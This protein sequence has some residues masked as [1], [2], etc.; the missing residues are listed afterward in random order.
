VSVENKNLQLNNQNIQ[1][2]KPFAFIGLNQVS[3]RF[4]LASNSLAVLYNDSF[5]GL[6]NLVDLDLSKNKINFI[7]L[8]AFEGLQSLNSLDLSSNNLNSTLR[9]VFA[10]LTRLETLLLNDNEIRLLNSDSFDGLDGLGELTLAN[11]K[12]K[13]IK[14]DF[15]S[16]LV[17]LQYLDLAFNSIS[18]IEPLSFIYLTNLRGL[19]L[20][21][22]CIYKLSSLLFQNQVLLSKLILS[23]N[24][25][26]NIELVFVNLT[27]LESLSL[28][29]NAIYQLSNL[30]FNGLNNLVYLN[31]SNN[32]LKSLN[33]SLVSLKSLQSI[34]L[35]NNKIQ[36][37]RKFQLFSDS[38]SFK[39]EYYLSNTSVELIEQIKWDDSMKLDLSFNDLSREI[40]N[41]PFTEMEDNLIYLNL[42]QTNLISFAVDV[43]NV[44]KI[45][46]FIDLSCNLIRFDGI[47]LSNL[48]KLTVLKLSNVN[49]TDSNLDTNLNFKSLNFL[50]LSLNKLETIKVKCLQSNLEIRHLNLS[51]N[52]IKSIENNLLIESYESYINGYELQLDV[53]SNCLTNLNMSLNALFAAHNNLSTFYLHNVFS[54]LSIANLSRNILNEI[55]SY[56]MWWVE[57]LDISFNS[58]TSI[59][60]SNFIDK[61]RLAKLYIASNLIET[62]EG[63]SFFIQKA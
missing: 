60:Q 32:F 48:T 2:I 34:D 62:I 37:G 36:T 58:V 46:T 8:N 7:E 13:F 18:A 54:L 27:K 45:L 21:D 41:I 19:S 38:E 24:L 17:A 4:N 16:K 15:F 11:N 6:L 56:K 40:F 50:D 31:L 39:L 20:S 14:N 59:K 35:S 12:I 30:T 33:E 63:N 1:E 47:F 44:L 43:L 28:S 23:S 51:Y 10:K 25:L 53:T 57:H 22:N 3:D 42:R 5:T 29:H 55:P 52:R 9:Q 61:D 26:T 49:L